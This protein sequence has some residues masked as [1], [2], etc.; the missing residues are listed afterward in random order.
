MVNLSI[1]KNIIFLLNIKVLWYYIYLQL[2]I[3]MKLKLWLFSK[4]FFSFFTFHSHSWGMCT[5]STCWYCWGFHC[6]LMSRHSCLSQHSTAISWFFSST[7]KICVI[8]KESVTSTGSRYS[9]T[10]RINWRKMS[11][12]QSLGEFIQK[13]LYLDQLSF[14]VVHLNENYKLI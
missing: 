4:I 5:L 11:E 8:V 10:G 2:K 3:T 9:C 14:E 1:Y 12:N 13:F 7:S 6:K